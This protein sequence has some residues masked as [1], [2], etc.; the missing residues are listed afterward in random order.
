MGSYEQEQAW[1]ILIAFTKL[2]HS[3]DITWLLWFCLKKCQKWNAC[4]IRM[5]LLSIIHQDLQKADTKVILHMGTFIG[6][7]RLPN[8]GCLPRT[9]C[10]PEAIYIPSSSFALGLY[11]FS[12][13][14][15]TSVLLFA[16]L[17]LL[18][19]C[20]AKRS[21]AS[22]CLRSR[23]GYFSRS[24]IYI[25]SLTFFVFTVP[26]LWEHAISRLSFVALF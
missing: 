14:L 25:F 5:I 4:A 8:A 21:C 20:I 24:R 22:S 7:I 18:S 2:C 3:N 17:Y 16:L 9:T 13:V 1:F 23:Q 10:L 19:V 11:L 15:S 12:D 26:R 6:T